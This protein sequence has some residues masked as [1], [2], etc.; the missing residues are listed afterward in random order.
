M[1]LVQ[2]FRVIILIA[3][4]L[5]SASA[6]KPASLRFDGGKISVEFNDQLHSRIISR[7]SENEQ[8]L[9][10]F[11]ISE[12]LMAGDED[13]TY[14]KFNGSS[15]KALQDE[16]GQG[17]QFIIRGISEN[18]QK[19]VI[20]NSYNDFPTMLFFKVRYRN[21][22]DEDIGINGWMNNNYGLSALPVVNNEPLFW[23]YQPGSYGWEND[24]IQ[25]LNAG[26]ER[27]NLFGRIK[28]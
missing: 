22:G 19:E 2:I 5:E 10:G 11:T 7:I 27:K 1:S 8:I 21:T 25:P 24:W 23:S 15:T 14:F 28:P 3:L 18:L 4:I 17:K 13:K 26:F 6:D 12:I 16:I 9:G 20:I